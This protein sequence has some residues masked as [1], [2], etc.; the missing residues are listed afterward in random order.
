MKL[1]NAMKMEME[2]AVAKGVRYL[3]KHN[4]QWFLRINLNTLDLGEPGLCILGQCYG[5]FWEALGHAV[6]SPS[7]R[8]RD[9]PWA[10]RYG[11]NVPTADSDE[12]TPNGAYEYLTFEWVPYIAV[13]QVREARRVAAAARA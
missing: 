11:F 6:T 2:L 13:R 10:I 1:N 8:G 12:E 7:G 9:N 3:D 4:P 5:S